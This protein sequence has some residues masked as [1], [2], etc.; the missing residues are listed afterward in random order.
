MAGCGC[1][2]GYST[3]TL[4]SVASVTFLAIVTAC[5]LALLPAAAVESVA[6]VAAVAARCCLARADLLGQLRFLVS[7][8]RLGLLASTQGASELGGH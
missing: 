8:S 4:V 2:S 6:S 5:R 1:G 3:S 7:P